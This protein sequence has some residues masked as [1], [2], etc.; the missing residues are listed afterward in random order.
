M[1]GLYEL[2][3]MISRF[4][5]VLLPAACNVGFYVCILA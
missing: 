2:S 4:Y 3:E 1:R 5:I